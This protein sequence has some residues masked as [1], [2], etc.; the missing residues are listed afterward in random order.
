MV[1]SHE[2]KKIIMS[3]LFSYDGVVKCQRNLNFEKMDTVSY[4]GK[5]WWGL[6]KNIWGVPQT[7]YYY[8][9]VKK[10]KCSFSCHLQIDKKINNV[11]KNRSKRKNWFKRLCLWG[12]SKK[13]SYVAHISF[14]T[15]RGWNIGNSRQRSSVVNSLGKFF[16]ASHK[17]SSCLWLCSP[18]LHMINLK[19]P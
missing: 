3:E 10:S 12:L 13:E 16:M 5:K 6:M 9:S 17:N 15:T 4:T 1:K 8:G 14:Y 11:N 19:N 2:K 7:K 18:S